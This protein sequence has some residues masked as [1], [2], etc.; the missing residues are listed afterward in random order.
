MVHSQYRYVT[1]RFCGDK[2]RKSEGWYVQGPGMKLLRGPFENELEA[3]A[4][5]AKMLKVKVGDLLR[6]KVQGP[7]V[8]EQEAVSEYR[9]VT[10]RVLRGTTYWMGQPGRGKQKLF[11]NMLQAAR[12]TAKERKISLN[13]MLKGS[14]L[15]GRRQ[16]QL[17]LATVVHIY[18]G[19]SEVPGDVE[20]LREHAHS[21]EAVVDQEPA[22]E[23]LD[24]QSKY[25]PYRTSQLHAF[26]QSPPWSKVHR[27][28]AWV[29]E[30][31]EEYRPVPESKLEGLRHRFGDD[32]LLRAHGLLAVLRRTAEAVHGADFSCW[33]TNCGRN[34]SH[35]SGFVP[36]LLRFK[37]LRKVPRSSVSP[38][39]L[40]STTG[41]CYQ[42]R[43]DNLLEVLNKLC[44]LVVLADAIKK[45]KVRGPRS[46]TAWVTA[47]RNLSDVVKMNPCPGMNNVTSYL[48]LWTMRAILLRRMY[49]S[50]AS[51]LRLDDSLFIDF[52]STFPDQKKMLGKI[53]EVKPSLTCK[54]ALTT[55]GY[56]GPPELLSMY[57]CFMQAIDKTSTQFLT[58]N[59]DTLTKHRAD[60]KKN[61]FQN[62]VLKELVKM[63]RKS[64]RRERGA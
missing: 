15:H 50:G 43:S 55:S 32:A 5:I 37:V 13:S 33:V 38:L 1:R 18:G 54:A 48:P 52:A 31:Q 24:V 3:A 12:W 61:N 21:M 44:K 11:K 16:Y 40:G 42:L 10:K 28:E 36:M 41:L 51:R 57:L 17:R 62:P 56:Q 14:A 34:V 9:F 47:F 7:P 64:L 19:G 46:C 2:S 39:D 22:M 25:G 60:Y 6:S 45:F 49:A 53:C 20:Y 63:V 30:L 26:R 8:H 35:H 29:E 4:S 59:V 23:I 58:K 27:S